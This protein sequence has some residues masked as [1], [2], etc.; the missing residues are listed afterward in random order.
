VKIKGFQEKDIK[1]LIDTDSSYMQPT[2][3]NIRKEL[4]AMCANAQPGDYIF[5]HFSGHGTQVPSAEEDDG[6]NEAICPTDMNLIVDDDL[7]DIANT[8]KK[9]VNFTLLTD[10]CHSGGMLD[11]KEVMIEG[12]KK[13]DPDAVPP[14]FAGRELPI[15]SVCQILSQQMGKTIEPRGVRGALSEK[16]GAAASKYAVGMIENYSGQKMNNAQKKQIAGFLTMCFSKLGVDG[17]QAGGAQSGGAHGGGGSSGGG[18]PQK[19]ARPDSVADDVGI[20]ITGCQS[21]ETSAD[22]RAGG[23]AYG[24]LTKNI[25]KSLSQ[26]PNANYYELVHMA[27]DGLA[28]GGFTQNPCLE[29]S[30]EN[31]KLPFI[32]PSV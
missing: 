30:D 18:A 11:H 24:A 13:K 2:G 32:C 4:S 12:D 22:V 27:R 1:I 5:M 28:S 31:A 16:Y 10:C 21:H 19:I 7:R 26:N 20:L 14:E 3:E 9:G 29:C 25:E 8:C 17:D 23:T 6:K 15:S